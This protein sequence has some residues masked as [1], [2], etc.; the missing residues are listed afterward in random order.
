MA[1]KTPAAK[2]P[3]KSK[4][5]QTVDADDSATAG[6]RRDKIASSYGH[7]SPA[8]AAATVQDDEIDAEKSV[9]SGTDVA[10]E[11]ESDN[12]APSGSVPDTGIPET[13]IS[14]TTPNTNSASQERTM[15]IA[16]MKLSK[17]GKYALYKGL[18]TVTRLSV[19]DF[20]NPEKP[21]ATLEVSG[22][23]AGP[24]EVLTKEQRAERRKNAPKP[25]LAEQIAKREKALARLK[26]KAEKEAVPA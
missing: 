22:E 26:A 16:F 4:K 24:R 9:A 2:K 1:K 25:T 21:P 12:V 10:V 18:R 3:S 13:G 6:A 5:V 11:S 8:P 17:S 14:K 20:P 23:L 7:G 19:T 15:T